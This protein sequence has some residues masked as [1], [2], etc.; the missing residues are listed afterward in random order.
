MSNTIYLITGANRGIG[1]GI[2]EKYLSQPNTTIIAAVRD[3]QAPTS[4]ELNNLP[5]GQS[6]QLILIEIDASNEEA[7][8]LAAKELSTKHNIAHIDILIANAGIADDYSP[9]AEVPIA[10][11]K[12]HVEI[13]AYGS[14]LLFQAFFPLLSKAQSPKFVAVGSPIGSI[15][16]MESRTYPMAAYGASKAMLHWFVRKIHQENENLVA[17]VVDPGFVQSDMGNTGARRF[18]MEKAFITIEDSANFIVKTID[19]STRE[20]TSGHFPTIEGGDFPF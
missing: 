9:V 19:E 3:A 15:T 16:G 11:V 8:S 18:G 10:K 13:N 17:F 1:R 12:K 5:K 4:K 2:A 20:K 7:P 6:S 14:L